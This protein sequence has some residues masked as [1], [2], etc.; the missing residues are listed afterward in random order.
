MEFFGLLTNILLS[1]AFWG[2]VIIAVLKILEISGLKLPFRIPFSSFKEETIEIKEKTPYKE[3]ITGALILRLLTFLASILILRLFIKTEEPFNLNDVLEIWTKWDVGHYLNLAR[4]GYSLADNGRR[5][6]VVF[7]P[8]YPYTVRIIS[9]FTAGSTA[10]AGFLVS[11]LCFTAAV[12]YLYRLVRIDYSEKTARRSVLYLSIFPFAFFFGAPFSE[13]IFLLTLV[14]SMYYA[15]KREWALAGGFGALCA[16]SR[17]AGALCALYIA[18]EFCAEYRIFDKS[19]KNKLKLIFTK[20]IHAPLVALGTLA[21][22]GINYIYTGNA[23]EFMTLQKEHWNT[24]AQYFGKTGGD[25]LVWTLSQDRMLQAAVWLPSL[26]ILI[27]ACVMLI[28]G[29][30]RHRPSDVIFLAAYVALSYIMSWPLSCPRYMT[31]AIPMF[32]F[33]AAFSEKRETWH[34][35]ITAIFAAVYGIYLV[36][37]LMGHQV[38]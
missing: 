3:L 12:C 11:N 32:V 24:H 26:V 9:F 30:R 25:L 23:L 27:F 6:F 35:Y 15:R 18:S 20:G 16:F 14:M 21:Y 1:A 8:L 4:S 29:A 31:C 10:A 22:M 7:F 36:A 13:S 19:T 2:A 34:N 17:M 33:L 38:M 5:V 28:Y 37:F